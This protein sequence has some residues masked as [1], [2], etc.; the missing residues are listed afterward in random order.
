MVQ[1]SNGNDNGNGHSI[2]IRRPRKPRILIV[3]PEITHLPGMG[4]LAQATN[5]KAGGPDVSACWSPRS[6]SWGPTSTSRYRTTGACST[7][8]WGG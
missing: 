4:N 1:N 8:T 3:T 7:W 6:S 5:A 2:S